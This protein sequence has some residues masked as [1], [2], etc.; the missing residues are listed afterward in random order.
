MTRIKKRRLLREKALQMLY[1]YTFNPDG[2]ELS[3][4]IILNDLNKSEDL[5]FV[6]SLVYKVIENKNYFEEIIKKK[7]DNW[8]FHR[9]AIID[10]ILLYIGICEFLYFPE[11]PP[12]VTINELIEIAKLFSTSNS[13][14]FINGILDQIYYDLKSS[15]K[16]IKS[17]RGLLEESLPNKIK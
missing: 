6:N 5:N 16:I 14:K 17:G 9:I 1:S 3:K 11:I 4:K 12:K 15:N 8:E 2:V 7:V 10:R 13:G